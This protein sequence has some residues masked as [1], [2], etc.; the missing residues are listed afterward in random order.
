MCSV[1]RC[2]GSYRHPPGEKFWGGRIHEAANIGTH[3]INTAERHIC[4]HFETQH[5]VVIGSHIVASP[6]GCIFLNSSKSGSGKGENPFIEQFFCAF[7]CCPRHLHAI[8]ISVLCEVAQM[9][10]TIKTNITRYL[11]APCRW[12]IH[13]V[14]QSRNA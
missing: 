12:L 7:S 2:K 14:P 4:E 9:S 8:Y 11:F 3:E 6:N 1:K 10:L 13:V 5:H